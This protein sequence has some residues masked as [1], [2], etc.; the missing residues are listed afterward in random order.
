[1]AQTQASKEAIWLTRLLSELDISY[2]LP[3]KPVY[4]KADNQGAIILTKDPRFYS[5]TKYIDIQ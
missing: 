5:R 1:M 3:K 4:I 2:G